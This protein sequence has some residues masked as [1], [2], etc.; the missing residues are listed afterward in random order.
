MSYPD[1]QPI[2]YEASG[3]IQGEK[4]AEVVELRS[5]MHVDG[6]S[7][8]ADITKEQEVKRAELEVRDIYA[9]LEKVETFEIAPSVLIVRKFGEKLRAA[10]EAA[11]AG[12]IYDSQ[13]EFEEFGGDKL[14]A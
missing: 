14:A 4:I 10:R 12:I 2:L 5:Q 8:M 13:Y 6:F 9:H 7:E 3:E 11:A 1:E